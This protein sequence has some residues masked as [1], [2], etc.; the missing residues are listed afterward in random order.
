MFVID[1]DVVKTLGVTLLLTL[2]VKTDVTGVDVVELVEH[3]EEIVVV[4]VAV[5]TSLDCDMVGVFVE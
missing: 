3:I 4:V 2:G 1:I 5:I